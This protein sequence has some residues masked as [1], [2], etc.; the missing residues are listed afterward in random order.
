[1]IEPRLD[2]FIRAM[3]KVELH[4]HL[5]GALPIETALAD[6]ER[7]AEDFLTRQARQNIRY[8]EFTWTAWA[9][10]VR[11]GWRF[12]DQLA[13]LAAARAWAKKELGIG[14]GIVIDIPRTVS[15]EDGKQVAQWAI[16]GMEAGV[17]GLG[18]AGPEAGNPPERYA[19]AFARA[20]DAGLP[21][22]PHAGE[23]V[24]P[25]SIWSALKAARA[26]RI[27]HG[28]HALDD[29]ALA[30]EL[31]R[32]RIALEVCPTSNL[33]LAGVA[34]LAD[35]PLPALI[36]AGLVVTLNSDDPALF[37]TTLTDEF[38][39]CAEAFRWTDADCERLALNAAEAALLPPAERAEL[40]DDIRAGCA[41]LR[42]A[43]H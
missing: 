31:A 27:G 34:R 16:A 41:K 36:K 30:N 28:I 10:F 6:V 25:E 39:K 12:D 33:R 4:V 29:P 42:R 38:L 32:R 18:L 37:D 43:G 3:P 22:V 19:D 9:H 7:I 40:A 14:S 21:C 5:G 24:G 20:W 26:Q 2:H 23:T 35:H 1:M 17:V 15:A 8:T 11:A 13:A